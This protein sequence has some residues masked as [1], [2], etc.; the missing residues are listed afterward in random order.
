MSDKN[1]EKGVIK[2]SLSQTST[3]STGGQKQVSS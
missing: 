2:N 1:T 3:A